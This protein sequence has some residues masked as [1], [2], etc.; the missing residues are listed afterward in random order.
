MDML[1]ISAA[2]PDASSIEMIGYFDREEVESTNLLMGPAYAFTGGDSRKSRAAIA[3]LSQ[4]LEETD[5]VGF[6]RV[7]RTK[8]GV[9]TIG[10]L[11]PMT[12]GCDGG[13][14][15]AGSELA[16]G[17]GGR[18]LAFLQLPFADDL[19]FHDSKPVP[20]EHYGDCD[21]ERACDDLIDAMMLPDDVLRSEDVSFP[22]LKAHQ[23][24]VAHFAMN[25]LAPEEEMKREGLGDERILEASRARP[26]CEFDAVRT[27]A[28]KASS[29]ID[30]FLET[31][32][33]IE[34]K[35]E[36]AKKRKFWG[37]DA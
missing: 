28:K 30:A 24:M 11:M 8:H 29:Q 5:K 16:N 6:C 23:R 7:V 35:P 33:L 21:D 18:Y 17:K 27:V 22:A 1:G 12:S 37:D 13:N 32:P 4:A 3:A 15:A 26:L 34:H 14:G 10:A 2:F 25:P 9:P 20:M 31:F 19:Q 36:D